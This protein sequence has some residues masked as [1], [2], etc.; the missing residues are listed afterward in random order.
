MHKIMFF[1][2]ETKKVV[3]ILEKQLN[4]PRMGEMV[5]K[6][7]VVYRVKEVAHFYDD[8]EIYIWLKKL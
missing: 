6:S 5:K 8:Q 3:F 7:G 1:E 2:A 4:I